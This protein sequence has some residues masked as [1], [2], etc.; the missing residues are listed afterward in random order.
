MD[1]NGIEELG[2]IDYLVVEFPADKA[3]FDGEVLSHLKSLVDGGLVR[4]LDLLLMQKAADGSWEGFEEHEFEGTAAGVLREFGAEAAELLAA[5]DI[6][7]IAEVLEPGTVAAVLVYENTWAAP[8]ASAVR[9]AG[10]QLVAQGRI[11][12]EGILA[13]IEADDEAAST[14]GA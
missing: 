11:P 12:M 14:E 3:R 4:V 13:A 7:A 2:P 9:R 5:E 6:E 8:F 1:E 10:G